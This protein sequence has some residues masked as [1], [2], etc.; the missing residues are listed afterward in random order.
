MS[1]CF[2]FKIKPYANLFQF[3]K[4]TELKLILEKSVTDIAIKTAAKGT[5][6][7]LGSLEDRLA[8]DDSMNTLSW[9]KKP[10]VRFVN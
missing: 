1:F 2:Y 3:E 4:E 5:D 7:G 6:S 8:R 10:L 9:V